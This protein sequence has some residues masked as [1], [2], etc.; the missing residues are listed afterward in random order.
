MPKKKPKLTNRGGAGLLHKIDTDKSDSKKEVPEKNI[1]INK[2]SKHLRETAPVVDIDSVKQDPV[3]ARLHPE[4]NM[5]SIKQSLNLYGQ[6]IPILV[7][8]E[9]NI[10]I[11]GNGR[12]R[13][14]KELGWTEIAISYADMSHTE[15]AGFGIVDNR[16]AELAKWDFEV[17]AQLDQ[18]IQ[19]AGLEQI[20][21]S[22]DELEILRM[23]E[24]TPPTEENVEPEDL[25]TYRVSFTKDSW[26]L[27][28]KVKDLIASESM[29]EL[30]CIIYLCERYL[31]NEL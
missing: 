10:I 17:L 4:R 19:E 8:R 26:F 1:T 28:K 20:G 7:N 9:T 16:T 29:D 15:A 23:A 31:N 6:L 14:A 13:C 21:W 11:A 22:V 30:E 24:W 3:N 18:L 12:H 5:K 27:L 25:M 2:I